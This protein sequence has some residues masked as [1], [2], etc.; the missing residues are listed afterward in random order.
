MR[1]PAVAAEENTSRQ[2]ILEPRHLVGEI[3]DLIRELGGVLRKLV[4]L[5]G[6]GL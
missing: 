5:R 6:R 1:E 3:P 4:E 2:R